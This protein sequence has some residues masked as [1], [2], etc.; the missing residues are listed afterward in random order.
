MRDIKFR[1]WLLNQNEWYDLDMTDSSSVGILNVNYPHVLYQY[2][3][4]Q[5]RNGIDIYEGDIVNP[6]HEIRSRHKR[7]IIVKWIATKYKIGFNIGEENDGKCEVLGN[8][9]QNRELLQY[10][11]ER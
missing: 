9:R 1:A 3:G 6:S 2:T 4:I 10:V 8:I 5:D 7:P 11:K